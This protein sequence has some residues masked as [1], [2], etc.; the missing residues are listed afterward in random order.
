MWEEGRTMSRTDPPP[1]HQFELPEPSVSADRASGAGSR[2]AAA[3]ANTWSGM[4][5]ARSGECNCSE[6]KLISAKLVTEPRS[7][8]LSHH[9]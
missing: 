6:H 5:E 1:Q 2:R 9:A 3:V 7:G 8:K 4:T